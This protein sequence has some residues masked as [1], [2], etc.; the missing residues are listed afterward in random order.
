MEYLE[1]ME[2][3]EH[4]QSQQSFNRT[5]WWQMVGYDFNVLY[6]QSQTFQR[7][8]V[9]Q[10]SYNEAICCRKLQMSCGFGGIMS[11]VE[12]KIRGK[13]GVSGTGVHGEL[14]T[15]QRSGA[16]GY[17]INSEYLVRSNQ[18]SVSFRRHKKPLRNLWGSHLQN[19]R[20][21]QDEDNV[22]SA[23]RCHIDADCERGGGLG[24]ASWW[25]HPSRQWQSIATHDRIVGEC[26]Q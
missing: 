12:Q 3:N 6:R 1:R 19:K 10:G 4:I 18:G 21:K 2:M 23:D 16:N 5:F 25:L 20:L 22:V 8:Y 14:D 11:D 15:T 24:E 26:V 17:S 9:H 13:H 7:L